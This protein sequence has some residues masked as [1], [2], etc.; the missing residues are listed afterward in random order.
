MENTNDSP[1]KITDYLE[2][3]QCNINITLEGLKSD[4]A[5][6]ACL[7]QS[8][9]DKSN[10]KIFSVGDLVLKKVPGLALALNTSLKGPYDITKKLRKC[11]ITTMLLCTK[12]RA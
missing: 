4:M 9:L 7:E 5:N 1:V 3:L 8:K 10:L 2:N 6:K 11:L 12:E